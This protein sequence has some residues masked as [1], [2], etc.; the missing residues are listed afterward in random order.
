MFNNAEVHSK[1]T[2]EMTNRVYF[3]QTAL[4]EQSEPVCTV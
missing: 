1:G 2:Q 4:Q 3:D